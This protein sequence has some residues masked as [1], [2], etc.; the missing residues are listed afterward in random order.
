MFNKLSSA[1]FFYISFFFSNMSC[2]S[3][4]NL[5]RKTRLK[6]TFNGELLTKVKQ[7][8]SNNKKNPATCLLTLHLIFFPTTNFFAGRLISVNVISDKCIKGQIPLICFVNLT[9]KP[10]FSKAT[11][12]P[13]K[14]KNTGTSSKG[15]WNCAYLLPN[16]KG[17]C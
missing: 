3:W 15:G 16:S 2:T 17:Q 13:F 12:S 7:D 1:L 9:I 4:I 8:N 11:I 6:K 5:G 10:K 14:T